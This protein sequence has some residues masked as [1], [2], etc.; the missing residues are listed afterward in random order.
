[1]LDVALIDPVHHHASVI[2][3][4]LAGERGSMAAVGLDDVAPFTLIVGEHAWTYRI[5][6]GRVAVEPGRTDGASAVSMSEAAWSDFAQFI[7]SAPALAI[8][9]ELE[10]DGD[11]G[12]KLLAKWEPAL[13][14]VYLGIPIYDPATADLADRNGDPLDLGRRFTLDDTD[15]EL[16]WFLDHVGFLHVQGVFSV[17][18]IEALNAEVDRLAAMAQPHDGR[19]WWAEDAAGHDVLCRLVYPNLGSDLIDGIEEDPRLRRLVDLLHPELRAAPDRM[20]GHSILI[21]APGEL[22]GLANIP[23]HQDCGLG[24]HPITCPSVAIGIQLTA[25]NAEVG[26]LEAIA[27]SHGQT[28]RYGLDRNFADVPHV[29]VDTE[30][31]DVTV[32]IADLMHASPRPTG[33]GNRRVLYVTYYPPTLFDQV[34]PGEAINDLV[35]DRQAEAATLAPPSSERLRH[36]AP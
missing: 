9:G 26:H 33:A 34:G 25:A 3:E 27:G 24:G 21:K 12:F 14:A 2:P 32:H 5:E 13:R 8:G 29:A 15:D 20:E 30:A 10:F 22:K 7:R 23:W 6:D 11:G 36:T 16:A 31:G 35:R 1:M 19:S 28:C 17:A 4:L 18:E